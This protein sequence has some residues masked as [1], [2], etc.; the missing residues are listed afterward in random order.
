VKLHLGELT[1]TS[2]DFV[3]GGPLPRY[4]TADGEH[5]SPALRWSSVPPG[6]RSFALVSTDPDAPLTH[7][8]D[9]W[10]L[11]N[12]PAATTELAKGASGVG[13]TGLNGIGLAE[14]CPASPPPGHGTHTYYFH[15][16]ALDCEPDLPEGLSRS[17]L[18]D[19]IDEHILVQARIS[20]TFGR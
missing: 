16:Y 7:G 20:G 9:H 1:I 8:F 15:L 17:S 13:T 18:L 5:A 4:A 11:Y 6:T 12:I 19:A 3:H 10:V 14:C 2:P